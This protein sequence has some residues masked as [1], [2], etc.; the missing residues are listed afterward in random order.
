MRCTGR[1]RSRS[2][3]RRR[4]IGVARQRGVLSS[5][6]S[7]VPSRMRQDGCRFEQAGYPT[8]VAGIQTV[9]RVR[10]AD[11]GGRFGCDDPGESERLRSQAHPTEPLSGEIV[12]R[13]H[14]SDAGWWKSDKSFRMESRLHVNAVHPRLTVVFRTALGTCQK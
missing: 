7:R 4:T 2:L 3:P 1:R 12:L 8:G 9:R 10:P 14:D 11:V 13:S 5:S 6:A